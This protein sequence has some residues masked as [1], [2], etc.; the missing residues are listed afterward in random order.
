MSHAQ[1]FVLYSHGKIRPIVH[2]DELKIAF[3]L[4]TDGP[5]KPNG[6]AMVEIDNEIELRMTYKV[7]PASCKE[8]EAS[9]TKLVEAC[10]AL[11]RTELEQKVNEQN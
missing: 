11:L 6:F 7:R 8:L 10:V 9:L 4:N 1:V 3:S 2:F 5:S